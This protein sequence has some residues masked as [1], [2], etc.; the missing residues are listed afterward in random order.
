MDYILPTRFNT[1]P[2]FVTIEKS[3]DALEEGDNIMLFP[4]K[5]GDRTID[6]AESSTKTEDLRSFYTGF[7]HI[8]KMYYDKTGRSLMFYPVYS[9]R[10]RHVFIIGSPV[11]YDP[12]LPPRES[13][14]YV[15]EQLQRAIEELAE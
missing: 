12:S 9:N 8:G 10:N 2:V 6:G 14:R 4:E 3:L 1:D 5:P 11:L 7:A 15:A 13:K